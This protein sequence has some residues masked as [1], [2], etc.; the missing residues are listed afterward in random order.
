MEWVL[1]FID[2]GG[3]ETCERVDTAA[4]DRRALIGALAENR[5]KGRILLS[6]MKDGPA[7][8][9]RMVGLDCAREDMPFGAGDI[10]VMPCAFGQIDLLKEVLLYAA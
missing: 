1:F 7:A 3:E 5:K 2:R 6:S 9:R 4:G 8:A 10:H